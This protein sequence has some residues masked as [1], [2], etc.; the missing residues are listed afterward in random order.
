MLFAV[1]TLALPAKNR[2]RRPCSRVSTALPKRCLGHNTDRALLDFGRHRLHPTSYRSPDP[3]QTQT[4]RRSRKPAWYPASRCAPSLRM[5]RN[6]SR[7]FPASHADQLDTYTDYP[8]YGTRGMR[9]AGVSRPTT[10]S[11]TLRK[12]ADWSLTLLLGAVGARVAAWSIEGRG[13]RGVLQASARVAK[14]RLSKAGFGRSSM[15]PNGSTLLDRGH[16]P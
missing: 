12:H 4:T 9:A 15:K 7:R 6:R 2:C 5:L 10:F 1:R 3:K 8:A 13:P 11:P 14:H 16:D